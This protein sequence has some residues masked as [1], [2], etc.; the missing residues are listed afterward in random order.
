[1]RRVGWPVV[2]ALG[3]AGPAGRRGASVAAAP[4]DT[5]ASEDSAPGES[6]SPWP[7][8]VQALVDG[9]R[10]GALPAEDG[11]LALS[12]ISA[13][14]LDLGDGSFLVLAAP[15]SEATLALAG[16]STGW[17]PAPMRREGSVWVG[18]LSAPSPAGMPYKLVADGARWGP[19][20]RSRFAWVDD[21][22]VYS[23]VR[24]DGPH[25]ERWFGVGT[26]A[27]APRTLQIL[28]PAGPPT[29]H[30]YAFD[31]Q[32]LFDP[33]APFGGW[34]LHR[35]VGAGTLVVAID[36]DPPN[37]R[38]EY[39]FS[40]DAVGGEEQGGA[41]DAHA[42]WVDEVIR[43]AVEARFGPAPVAGALGASMGGLQ[44]FTLA[45]SQ[46]GRWAFAGSLSGAFVW[47]SRERD[48]ETF[49]DRVGAFNG[50]TL[51]LDSGGGDG[52]GCV[53]ADG[54]GLQDD[55]GDNAGVELDFYCVNRQLADTLAA[56]GWSWGSSLHHWYAPGAPHDESAWRERVWRPLAVFE[57]L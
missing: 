35:S 45:F 20:P 37:R 38:T 25:L 24:P 5:G 55:S 41:G 22:G 28:V 50:V 32:N 49:F 33:A 21:F 16:P 44:A 7:A 14:P 12:H 56:A 13:L 1:V 54:D 31:G 51:Y 15:G 47:G 17:S 2:V 19:D 3:C 42:A 6:A 36:N 30:L 29:H 26:A 11:L 57:A 18:I 23:L 46:P 39:G 27:F 8:E 52:G 43:P 4:R 40:V 34:A 9:L 10:A 48:N 53:D